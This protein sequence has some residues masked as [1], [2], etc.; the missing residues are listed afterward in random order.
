LRQLKKAEFTVAA[1]RLPLKLNIDTRRLQAGALR[2]VVLP[3]LSVVSA[4]A[5]HA[6]SVSTIVSPLVPVDFE[7]GRNVGV[8]E[9]SDPNFS[10]LGVRAGGLI[11]Y[12]SISA[13][14]AVS[15]NVY[16]NNTDKRSDAFLTLQPGLRVRSDWSRHSFDLAASSNVVRYAHETLRNREE[17]SVNAA[18]KLEV[19]SQLEAQ[20]RVQ[21]D[22]LAESPFANDLAADVSVLS[23]YTRF[24]PNLTVSFTD[25][26]SRFT[27]SVERYSFRFNTIRFA[28]GSERDQT[29]RDKDMDR[30]ALQADYA[31]S[32]SVAAYA[33][34]NAEH[35]NY[36]SDRAI[37]VANRDGDAYRFIGGLNL[38]LAGLMRGR[39]GVGYVIRNYD[40][41]LYK[42]V[43]GVSV[44]S[45]LAFFV[46]PLTTV[47]LGAQ[48]SLQDVNLGNSGAYRDNRLTA[49]VDHALLRNLLVTGKVIR[50]QRK[51][52]EG[53]SS[54]QSVLLLSL[55][56]RYQSNR[57]T[58]VSFGLGY[59]RGR[60]SGQSASVPF[61]EMRGQV[62]VQLRL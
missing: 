24:V 42:D 44:D 1:H 11:L 4:G 16:L 7:R 3:A 59:G 6:Q 41:P 58:S 10:A 39:I 52:L 17:Y 43:A 38:D 62:S 13:T 53:D 47:T 27:G 26:R 14:S 12:P 61:D 15:D 19:S 8:A 29:N 60:S 2:C 9:T 54:S 32:P 48:S 51:I 30:V 35:T 49:T 23:Q 18:G 37:G 46:S 28:D 20:L 31:L 36:L 22:R 50:S 55:D 40:S 45:E 56:A 34:F 21:Y 57:T 25:G 33:Q 5:A